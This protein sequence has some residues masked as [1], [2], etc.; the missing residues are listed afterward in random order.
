MTIGYD[1]DAPPAGAEPQFPPLLTGIEVKTGVEPFEKAVADARIGRA[2]I[3]TLYWSPDDDTL[4]AAI[5][6][7]PE[8]PLVD[9]APILFAVAN[10]LNDCIGA[11]APPELGLHHVWPDGVRVNGALCGGYRVQVSAWEGAK[12]P[13]WMVIGLTLALTSTA[14]DP[15]QNPDVTA[16]SEEGCG[17]LSRVRLLESWSRHTLLWVNRWEED[18]YRPIFEAWLA[19]AYGRG[20]ETTV[21]IG[22]GPVSG[23][24]LGLDDK[25]GLLMKTP[26][27]PTSLS[28]LSALEHGL[29]QDQ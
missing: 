5:V 11:L 19:R 12:V 25:G 26:D 2:E 22:A 16:L 21:D 17:H 20:G 28:L 8:I 24:F 10:G 13:E 3:G 1:P 27:G 23:T 4:R 15:G 6:F 29:G 14:D 9:A 7:E 18:G